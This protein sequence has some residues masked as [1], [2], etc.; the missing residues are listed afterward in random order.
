MSS[1][2]REEPGPRSVRE[3]AVGL[4]YDSNFRVKPGFHTRALSPVTF[5][6]GTGPW[7]QRGNRV[8]WSFRR[9]LAAVSQ[10]NLC[11]GGREARSPDC[12]YLRGCW[13]GREASGVRI[14][15]GT[16]TQAGALALGLLP[17]WGWFRHRPIGVG[18]G[19]QGGGAP[20]REPGPEAACPHRRP[21][22][23]PLSHGHPDLPPGSEYCFWLR[24]RFPGVSVFRGRRWVLVAARSP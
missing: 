5:A 10:R 4:T 20:A 9:P 8:R 6:D 15:A 23:G 24:S 17:S 14:D 7:V 22:T 21:L 3:L 16:G 18:G 11:P 12:S 19:E 13:C 1:L 2:T